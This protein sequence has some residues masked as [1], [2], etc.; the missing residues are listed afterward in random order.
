MIPE[1]SDA[2]S[3]APHHDIYS[4]EDLKA[5]RAQ[6][7]GGNRVE[8]AGL[9]QD[10][11]C[12]QLGRDCRRDCPLGRRCRS[13]RR[14]P[15]R[16]GCSTS[17]SSATT[18]VSR[19]KP[20]LQALTPSCANRGSV[21]RSRSLQAAAS[22][23]APISRRL[24]AWEP[25]R[26][27]SEPPHSLPWA[28]GSAVPATGAPAP[29]ALQ[30]SVPELTKRLDPVTNSVQV[31]NLIHA[32]TDEIAELMGAAGINSIESLRGNRDSFERIHA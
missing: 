6:P 3:P 32:W 30:P 27:T 29:G 10:R 24:S 17:G 16:H 25:T 31:A 14:V 7:Q 22:A 5:A 20:R 11:R 19:S 4:I 2:I 28:A 1:G 18:W 21:T 9:C 15:W 26:S 23:R 12:P 13:H 8:E